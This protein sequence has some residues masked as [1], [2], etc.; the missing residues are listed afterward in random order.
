MGVRARTINSS[1][2]QD[3]EEVEE[4]IADDEV[5]VLLIS[6]ERLGNAHFLA[7]VL[8]PVSQRVA[9]L[10]VDEAGRLVGALS[11][12]DLMRAGVV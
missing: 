3:W 7:T 8:A 12:H 2:P 11:M 10:V 6:P 1:N 4:A 5:D 9:L